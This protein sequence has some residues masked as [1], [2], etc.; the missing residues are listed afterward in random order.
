[1]DTLGYI[2]NKYNLTVGDNPMI[3]IPGVSR[4]DFVRWIREL[5]F[6]VGAEIGVAQGEFSKLIIVGNHQVHL[7]GIDPWEPYKDYKDYVKQSSF[8]DLWHEANHRLCYFKEF[9]FI[10]KYSMDA[11]KDFEDDSLDF[12]YIDANHEYD[13]VLQ[14]ITEWT[15]KVKPGGMVAGHDYIHLRTPVNEAGKRFKYGIKRAIQDYT[16]ENNI[17]PWFVLGAEAKEPKVVREAI[18]SWMFVKP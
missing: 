16:K 7:Y 13:Y 4:L 6:K 10:R 17:S 5:D 8:D 18:R 11:V 1:M 14:D 2:L 15:K 9:E 3:E 12:V